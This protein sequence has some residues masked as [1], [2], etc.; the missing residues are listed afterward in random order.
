MLA[1]PS[2]SLLLNNPLE[3]DLQ[4][5]SMELHTDVLAF[6]V[7]SVQEIEA[8]QYALQASGSRKRPRPD[9]ILANKEIARYT[10]AG[11]LSVLSGCSHCSQAWSCWFPPMFL[12]LGFFPTSG[13]A[14]G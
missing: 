1:A 10:K 9:P 3:E 11:P 14:G 12:I 7:A 8:R 2:T 13:E 6:M 4:V 5:A